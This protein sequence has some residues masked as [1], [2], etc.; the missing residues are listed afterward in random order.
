[1]FS[2]ENHSNSYEKKK[3]KNQPKHSNI[4]NQEYP[5]WF[6]DLSSKPLLVWGETFY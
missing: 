2:F 1:M 5:K 3:R 6:T 4:M